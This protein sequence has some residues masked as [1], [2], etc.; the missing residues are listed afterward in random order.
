VTIF[1]KGSLIG[2]DDMIKNYK[3][4]TKT[5][6]CISQK[7]TLFELKKEH[8]MNLKGN[9]VSWENVMCNVKE[10]EERVRHRDKTILVSNNFISTNGEVEQVGPSKMAKAMENFR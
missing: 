4:Y 1:N 5:L 7:G 9:N 3:T 10:K 2:E 6:Q 8:F